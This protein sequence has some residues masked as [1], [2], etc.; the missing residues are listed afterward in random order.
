VLLQPEW[1]LPM[2]S[3]SC[4]SASNSNAR[5]FTPVRNPPFEVADRVG[6]PETRKRGG[7][8]TV[9]GAAESLKQ[10]LGSSSLATLCPEVR[11]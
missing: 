7:L 8:A 1:T 11:R 4:S 6:D 9:A 3:V 5:P 10:Y 2:T